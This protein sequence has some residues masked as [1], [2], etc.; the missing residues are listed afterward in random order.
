MKHFFTLLMAGSIMLFT[1]CATPSSKQ[2]AKQ[3]EKQGTACCSQ[4]TSQAKS[5]CSSKQS[6]AEVT[7]Y[8]FHAT[9]RCATCK[10]VEAVTQ[11][12]LKEYYGE[13]VAFS[14]INREEDKEMADQFKVNG[15]SLLI[16]KGDK[17]VDLTNV[18]FLNARTNPETLKKEIKETIDSMI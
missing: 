6:K 8:Y 11:E 1:Q 16:V 13:K 17:I 5:C 2:T 14:S 18:A 3:T 7:A 10:A 4:S 12:A 15:Q 9:R